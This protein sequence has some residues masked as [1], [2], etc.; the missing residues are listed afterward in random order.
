MTRE[1]LAAHLARLKSDLE[2]LRDF[3]LGFALCHRDLQET[4]EA[5]MAE[6]RKLAW[7]IASQPEVSL[8]RRDARVSSET[9][10]Q[11][12]DRLAC[13][14]DRDLDERALELIEDIATEFSM[15]RRQAEEDV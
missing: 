3:G 12:R 7:L 14:L 1:A 5:I 2:I 9:A 4:R 13:V 10:Y 15:A 6:Q 11:I 8:A